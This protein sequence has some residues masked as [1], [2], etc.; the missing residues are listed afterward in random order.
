MVASWGKATHNRT[1]FMAMNQSHSFWLTE[2]NFLS[3][4]WETG[5]GVWAKMTKSCGSR[6]E[7]G[8]E[9]W[10]SVGISTRN[11]AGN[12]VGIFQKQTKEVPINSQIM[13][14]MW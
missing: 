3:E 6:I 11:D 7:A 10:R 9:E 4:E 14:W 8:G 2:W 1:W 5:N 13:P 12:G